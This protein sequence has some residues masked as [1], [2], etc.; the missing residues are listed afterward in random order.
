[1]ARIL[2]DAERLRPLPDNVSRVLRML[3]GQEATAAQL[4]TVITRDQA[5]TAQV[6][7]VANSAALGYGPSCANV[8]DAVMR[9]GF[10][11]LRTVVLGLGASGAL[12]KRLRGYLL[13]AGELWRHSLAAASG[14]LWLARS[15]GYPEVEEA[16]IAGLLHDIG[17]LLLDQHVQDDYRRVVEM[18][19]ERGLY[20]WQVEEDLFGIDHAGAGGLMAEKW[21][22]PVPLVDAI[23]YHHAPS[24]AR[25]QQALAAIVNVANAWTPSD[26]FASAPFGGRAVHP[27][28]FQILGLAEADL[29]DMRRSMMEA[30]R[31][32]MEM[33]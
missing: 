24:L 3:E 28:V 11:R 9:L 6:L 2:H 33:A 7:R 18:V 17:K 29:D 10:K 5:L 8:K 22:F 13:G 1:M 19:S 26:S 12:R 15:L 23:R 20:L 27:E 16:Y 31:S 4:A 32:G 25:T 21:H 30:M 14:A